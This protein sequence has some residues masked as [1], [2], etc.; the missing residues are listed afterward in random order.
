[1]KKSIFIT[2]ALGLLTI[3]NAIGQQNENNYN[4]FTNINETVFVHGNTTTLLTGETFYYKFYTWNTHTGSL[5]EIS[6]IGYVELVKKNG[7]SVLKQKIALTK[8]MGNGSFFIPTKL[9]TGNYKL[10]AYTRWMLNEPLTALFQMDILIINP[11]QPVLESSLVNVKNDSLKTNWETGSPKTKIEKQSNSNLSLKKYSYAPREKVTFTLSSIKNPLENGHYS[12]SV[13][14]VDKLQEEEAIHADKFIK[15]LAKNQKQNF[16][17]TTYLPE[18]RGELIIGKIENKTNPVDVNHKSVALSIPGKNFV[19]ELVN[20]DNTGIFRFILNGQTGKEAA[21]IQVMEEDRQNY[22]ITLKPINIDFSSLE[23]EKLSLSQD[24]QEIIEKRSIA[25]QVENAYYYLKK[26]ST[27]SGTVTKP[28]YFPLAEEYVLDNYTR[29]PSLEKTIV[30]IVPQMYANKKKGD[31]AIHMREYNNNS[32]P[33]IYGETLVLVDGLLLQN[34][35]KFF[36]YDTRKI[37]KI[38]I[39][40]F[41]YVYGPKIFDGIANF[42]TKKQDFQNNLSGDF[43]IKKELLRPLPEKVYFQPSYAK[44]KNLRIPDFRYQL[45]WLPKISIKN[46]TKE[47]SFYTSDVKG[48]FELSLEGFTLDGKPVSMERTF[49]V[50]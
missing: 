26:D 36:E 47:I 23:F 45:L 31:Y 41:G 16:A 17:H 44:E 28:F 50:E 11:F 3:S 48:I 13:R 12:L 43:V 4:I 20:T 6:K 10:V 1:M 49:M 35:N 18:L 32:T 40:P 42:T 37:D 8:G 46:E 27:L 14:K 2:F 29:F 15:L 25:I 22:K 19:F 39:V 24:L 7:E 21:V 5:S 9:E 33:S 34:L 30:E 38:S